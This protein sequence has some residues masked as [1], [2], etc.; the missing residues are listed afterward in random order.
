MHDHRATHLTTLVDRLGPGRH[1]GSITLFAGQMLEVTR[2]DRITDDCQNYPAPLGETRADDGIVLRDTDDGDGQQRNSR[3]T[4]RLDGTEEARRHLAGTQ[5]RSLDEELGREALV[6]PTLDDLECFRPLVG[7]HLV[8]MDHRQ[9]V[10]L[11][12][13]AL[14]DA[15]L[16]VDL[17]TEDGQR[18]V[19]QAELGQP[20]RSRREPRLAGPDQGPSERPGDQDVP[21]VRVCRG[22]DDVLD[23][24]EKRTSATE[25]GLRVEAQTTRDLVSV[26]DDTLDE[27]A[28]DE[29]DEPTEE[30][31]LPPAG[32]PGANL[33][34]LQTLRV[35]L[36]G[37]EPG[38]DVPLCEVVIGHDRSVLQEVLAR[39]RVE[40]IWTHR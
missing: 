5:P 25:V 14:P 38:H 36:L 32:T 27:Q 1:H 20:H 35:L 22:D 24:P 28:A 4:R 2:I 17:R 8:M 9:V 12:G 6:E 10:V 15:V 33:E 21:L 18:A 19:V 34:V 30:R 40:L 31:V 23:A 39:L 29:Q 7:T 11:L 26:D 13:I 37:E 16:A 3:P